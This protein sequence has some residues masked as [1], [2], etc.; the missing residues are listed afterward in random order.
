MTLGGFW[1]QFDQKVRRVFRVFPPKIW[2]RRCCNLLWSPWRRLPQKT[3]WNGWCRCVASCMEPGRGDFNLDENLVIR[4]GVSNIFDGLHLSFIF[5]SG[6]LPQV[7]WRRRSF[8]LP[9][10]RQSWRRRDPKMLRLCTFLWWFQLLTMHDAS[11]C[12]TF[13]ICLRFIHLDD[14]WWPQCDVTGMM[15]RGTIPNVRTFQLFLGSWEL[16]V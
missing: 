9:L 6:T 1:G 3:A 16:Q 5:S 7:A 4:T 14:L 15:V 13:Y 11:W 2:G 8:G 10:A 12:T